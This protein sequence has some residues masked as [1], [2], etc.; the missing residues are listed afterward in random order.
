[1]RFGVGTVVC[2][3]VLACAPGAQAAM[4][5][6]SPSG[7]GTACTSANP[8]SLKEAA[9]K[10]WVNDEVI[11]AAGNYSIGPAPVIVRSGAQNV[12]VHGDYSGPM[13]HI[14][15]HVAEVPPIFFE[16]NGGR[17]AYVEIVNEAPELP[18]AAS[19]IFEGI[20]ERVHLVARGPGAVG[21][22]QGPGC[23]VRDSLLQAEGKGA[24]A[25]HTTDSE[26]AEET[27][28]RARNV[29]AIAT[30][31]DSVGVAVQYLGVGPTLL[32]ELVLHNTIASGDSYDLAAI[33][34]EPGF[35]KAILFVGNSNFDT[36]ISR[37]PGFGP[38][39]PPGTLDPPAEIVQDV[40]NQSAPP[41]FVD[42]AGG[43]FREA[44]GSPTIDA[45]QPR[46]LGIFDLAGTPR[47]L[48]KGPDI[49]AYEATPTAAPPPPRVVG[50]IT[51]LK[52]TPPRFAAIG[53]GTGARPGKPG[54]MVSY[55]LTAPA[56]V[57]FVVE[58]KT[59]GRLVKGRCRKETRFNDYGRPCRVFLRE[60]HTFSRRGPRSTNRFRFRGRLGHE[61]LEP[62]LYRLV[63]SA[64]GARRRAT[65][66]VVG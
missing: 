21:L 47:S 23:S 17:L 36:S 48:G 46:E 10:A 53:T 43:N 52:L 60:K 45:G 30:G 18:H 34:P 66:R 56:K 61:A 6:A 55:R 27:D 57:H 13:P 35:E 9:N 51:S 42:A 62:G 11:L 15:A 5:Y 50:R 8:C 28:A 41:L 33:C 2:L 59:T 25:L 22:L 37:S 26:T 3:L 24:V 31:P 44:V 64:G 20:V 38:P 4:H 7:T 19:C 14:D 49:G 32:I 29:T 39:Y 63:G 40:G 65:F 12:S 54:T 58:H 1:M 16:D